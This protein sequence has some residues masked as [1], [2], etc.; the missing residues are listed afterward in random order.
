[1]QHPFPTT[2]LYG[3]D[4]NP[5]QWPEDVWL[6]DM[7]LMKLA[8]VTMA[9]INIF[10]WASLE[11]AP[12]HY[13][14]DQLD[15]IMDMLTKNG[16]AAD[17][18]TAT[19]SPPTWMSRL[20]PDMLPVT[21]E[22][23]RLSHGS[24]QHYCPNSVDFRRKTA[25]L[26]RRLA[27]RYATHPA[28]KLWHVNNE[29]GCHVSA[30]YCDQSAAAFRKWLQE[31]YESLNG[32]NVAWGTDFWSQ[33]Y[34]AW[35]DV[36]PPRISPTHNNPGQVLD[37]QR[38][39]SDSLL[40][41]YLTE[42]RI[43]R[44]ITPEIPITTNF[45]N[46]F[47][48]I[49]YFS[50]A[51]HLD[52]IS[53]DSY[54]PNNVPAW[55]TAITDDLMH[56]LKGGQPYLLM[57]QSSSQVNWMP[58]NPHK[59]PGRMSMLSYQN[60]AHGAD[61]IM[62][63]QWRQSQAG[64]E[65]FHSA[66]VTHEGNEHNRIFRQA[67]QLG[68]ELKQ[69][70]ADVIGSRPAAQVAMLMDWQNWWAIEYPQRPSNRLRYW[71]QFKT[72]YAPLHGLNVAIDIVQPDSDLTNYRLLVVPLLYMLRPGV[73]KNL[74]QFVERGG[75]LLITYFSGIVDQNDR[76]ALGG[77]PGELR[78]LLGIHV[79]EF[80]P[81]TE[82]MTNQI[83]IEEGPLQGTYPCTLWGEVVHLEGARAIGVFAHDYYAMGPAL[84]VHQFGQ[85]Q[86]YYMATQGSDELLTD[87]MRLLCQ[88]AS[89]SPVLNVPEG[90]EVTQRV[91]ADGR[92][93]YFLLNHTDKP[94]VVA[95]PVGKFTSPLNGK[96]VERQIEIDGRDVAVLVAQ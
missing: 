2:I 4:Y 22:G 15:R 70:S 32:L 93:V 61:G 72:Y 74:E 9:S 60:L 75:V 23:T 18:A 31:R 69:L 84:T 10:S 35:E 62:F 64:A 51:P 78:K 50:W 42:A 83:V 26:V 91:R 41:C 1:M 20:Y 55:E 66:V 89:V 46:A 57:E 8:N 44:E 82:N 38:F 33:H 67:A 88:Q 5:E 11:P 92:V 28:L 63:F 95:L 77:Y 53:N 96:E 13:Q 21:R 14:F 47:K 34:Y 48:P 36:L 7:R 27:E 81:W 71:E 17:L 56:S 6:E 79:E 80:D 29:Y 85:G 45:M 30:C 58:Q 24:R 12:E 43:L 39:M 68:A 94:E 76:V 40:E 54:P 37:Y 87:L 25:E 73:A 19:A 52:I 49:D 86:A 65:K 3:G 90:I 16:I 59:R